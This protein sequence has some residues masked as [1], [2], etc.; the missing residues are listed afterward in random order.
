MSKTQRKG[1][2]M[3]QCKVYVPYVLLSLSF[4]GSQVMFYFET[5]D[6]FAVCKELR[7]NSS[8]FLKVKNFGKL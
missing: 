3:L 5:L 7:L 4:L 1:F 6:L 2:E 8:L